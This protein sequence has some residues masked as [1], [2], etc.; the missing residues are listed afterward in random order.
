MRFVFDKN[1]IE[2][3]VFISAFDAKEDRIV[4]E[5]SYRVDV[6]TVFNL[7]TYYSSTFHGLEHL[8]SVQQ[9]FSNE[10]KVLK[11]ITILQRNL[12]SRK[13]F[14]T[15]LDKGIW[16]TTVIASVDF[17]QNSHYALSDFMIIW[18]QLK[19]FASFFD[20][21]NHFWCKRWAF[22]SSFGDSIATSTTSPP[23]NIFHLMI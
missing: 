10:Q 15:A 21:W 14:C 8:S 5:S 9:V 16:R 13:H 23:G 18:W 20:G 17:P 2:D 4:D 22:E 1:F 12:H 6:R 3:F 11:K 19:S 7:G